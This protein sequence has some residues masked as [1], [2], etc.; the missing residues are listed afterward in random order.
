M[1][2]LWD[3]ALVAGA[4]LWGVA[5]DDAHDYDDVGG[6]RYPAGGAW[7]AVRARRDPDSILAALAA[8]RF[9]AS[10]GVE[11]AQAGV[12]DGALVVEVADADADAGA[13]RIT[14]IGDG[15]VLA[16]VD[17]RSARWPLDGA[18]S[19]VRA[20]VHRADGARAWVQPA[21]PTR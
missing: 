4:T 15:R 19:Y 3:A 10:T 8:G 21:R 14:F 2:A 16:E 6:G 13:H 11:L 18:T 12:V 17:G 7:V 20:V 9:Y 1:D 5:S